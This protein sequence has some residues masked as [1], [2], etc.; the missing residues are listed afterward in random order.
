MESCARLA[1]A[2]RGVFIAEK[3]RLSIGR[4]L[5]ARPTIYAD[6]TLPENL[7]P[8]SVFAGDLLDLLS[9]GVLLGALRVNFVEALFQV[10]LVFLLQRGIA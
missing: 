3:G 5:P 2:L 10:I 1:I 4:R 8:L 6:S 7:V 9:G